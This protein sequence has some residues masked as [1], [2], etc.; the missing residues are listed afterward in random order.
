[1]ATYKE[2]LSLRAGEHTRL[3]TKSMIYYQSST[4]SWKT[5]CSSLATPIC[6][7]QGSERDKVGMLKYSKPCFLK[8]RSQLPWS[9]TI[10]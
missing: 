1:M 6:H 2:I 10:K 7:C 5:K 9:G 3:I 4:D 8:E